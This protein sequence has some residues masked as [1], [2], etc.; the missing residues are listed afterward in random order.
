MRHQ[1]PVTAGNRLWPVG[2]IHS[3]KSMKNARLRQLAEVGILAVVY[4]ATA[5]IGLSLEAVE[6]F[7][8]L[9]WPPTG[10]ALVAVLIFGRRIWPGVAIGTIFLSILTPAPI[11]V[12]LGIAAGNTLEA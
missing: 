7:A 3:F 6:G 11:P 10:I 2:R 5:R 8:T 12:A 9:V 4:V 1:Q